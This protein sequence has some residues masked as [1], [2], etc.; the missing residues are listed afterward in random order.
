M[1]CHIW[2]KYINDEIYFIHFKEDIILTS[3]IGW[4]LCNN[5]KLK[6]PTKSK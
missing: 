5:V 3:H 6:I 4:I 2:L 1:G